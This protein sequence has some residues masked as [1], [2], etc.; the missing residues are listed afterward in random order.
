MLRQ[1]GSY[2]NGYEKIITSKGERWKCKNCQQSWVKNESRMLDHYN[3][4]RFAMHNLQNHQTTIDNYLNKFTNEDQKE[5]ESLLARAFYSTGI[6]FNT[7]EN[8]EMQAFFAKAC[9]FFKLPTRQSLS[10]TL[11]TQEY[12]DITTV[13][14]HLHNEIQVLCLATDGWLN[15]HKDSIINYMITT[16]KQF[17][18]NLYK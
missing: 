8:S 1:K 17:F 9:P 6:S 7:L 16:P 14:N 12:N 2:W 18:I 10:T 3:I 13:V 15:I 11:L 5:L 4:C